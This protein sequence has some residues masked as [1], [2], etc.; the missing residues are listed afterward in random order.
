MGH[1]IDGR[2]IVAG[3]YIHLDKETVVSGVVVCVTRFKPINKKSL[4]IL[5][6][7]D[8]ID[9]KIFRNVFL[10]LAIQVHALSR[11]IVL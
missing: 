8:F 5:I 7:S 9:C 2:N 6:W 1:S 4:T 10:V 3:I 11:Q